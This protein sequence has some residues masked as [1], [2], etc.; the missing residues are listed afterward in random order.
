MIA[1]L[2]F[3]TFPS[4]FSFH[5]LE[6]ISKVILMAAIGCGI[7]TFWGDAI[8]RFAIIFILCVVGFGFCGPD[9]VI[10]GATTNQLVGEV[11]GPKL[12]SLVNGL[13]TLVNIFFL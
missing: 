1:N 12:T 8:N 7:L 13:G 6:T 3:I 10:N 2:F 9:S 11:E 5:R 4:D